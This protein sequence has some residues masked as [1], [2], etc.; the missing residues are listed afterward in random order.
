MKVCV[1]KT[2]PRRNV[3]ELPCFCLFLLLKRMV[4]YYEPTD[5]GR[6]AD[7][8]WPP[9]VPACFAR[10]SFLDFSDEGILCSFAVSRYIVFWLR[11]IVGVQTRGCHHASLARLVVVIFFFF[12]LAL[13]TSDGRRACS[14]MGGLGEG[15]D[16]CP[17]SLAGPP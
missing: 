2:L 17:C 9:L 16:F 15:A 6:R 10:K 13:F 14:F 4:V 7:P 12:E 1:R 11:K 5:L 3:L 8:L